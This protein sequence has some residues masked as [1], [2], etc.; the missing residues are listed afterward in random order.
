MSTIK[1]PTTT[2]NTNTITTV[3]TTTNTVNKCS[4]N[5]FSFGI[6]LHFTFFL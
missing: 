1:P 4:Y 5:S 6:L 3:N 2:T